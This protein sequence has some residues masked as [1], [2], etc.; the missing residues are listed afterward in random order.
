VH[1]ATKAHPTFT[2][3]A[4]FFMSLMLLICGNYPRVICLASTDGAAGVAGVAGGAG[5]GR[6][7]RGGEVKPAARPV[8]ASSADCIEKNV[9][10]QV[11]VIMEL[12]LHEA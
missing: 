10:G 1:Q 3:F 5:V 8:D 2:H 11:F 4:L 12:N 9:T 6:A 7:T